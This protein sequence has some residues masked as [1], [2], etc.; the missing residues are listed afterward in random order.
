MALVPLEHEHIYRNTCMHRIQ[1][2]IRMYIY[3][4]Y[5]GNEKSDNEIPQCENSN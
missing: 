2:H 5:W 1:S 4:V 3:V